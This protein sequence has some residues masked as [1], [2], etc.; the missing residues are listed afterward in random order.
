M[1]KIWQ[2]MKKIEFSFFSF[3][4]KNGLIFFV[5]R[6]KSK[7]EKYENHSSDQGPASIIQI[8]KILAKRTTFTKSKIVS[9]AI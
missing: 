7:F 8:A 9:S 6:E 1:A 5:F 3:F 2:K 4:E